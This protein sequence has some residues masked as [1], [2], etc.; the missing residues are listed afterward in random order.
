MVST[1]RNF[2]LEEINTDLVDIPYV[3]NQTFLQK[4]IFFG[5]I[6]VGIALLIVFNI[7]LHLPQMLCGLIFIAFA[8][9]GAL[10]GCNYNQDLTLF[11]YIRYK[12]SHSEKYL[13]PVSTEDAKY[14]EGKSKSIESADQKKARALQTRDPAESK[15]LLRMLF[16]IGVIFAALIIGLV[17]FKNT[18]KTGSSITDTHTVINTEIQQKLSE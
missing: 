14:I 3:K 12:F 9:V 10:F 18:R 17:V 6:I 8:F 7:V 5:G 11:Q 1:R 13:P 2:N 15:R 4:I 16:V